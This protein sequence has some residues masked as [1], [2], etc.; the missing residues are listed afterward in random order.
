MLAPPLALSSR[1]GWVGFEAAVRK[2]G[3]YAGPPTRLPW[4][5]IAAPI[6]EP[7]AGSSRR[8]ASFGLRAIGP[9][10][11]AAS[12]LP[13]GEALA[14]CLLLLVLGTLRCSPAGD[15]PRFFRAPFPKAMLAHWSTNGELLLF[16]YARLGTC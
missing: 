15:S 4:P 8:S 11:G 9:S 13:R 14:L 12:K 7:Y 1:N 2:P 6:F 16:C 3:F 10:I 5:S